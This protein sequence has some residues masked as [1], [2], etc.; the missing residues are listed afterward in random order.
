MTVRGI[1]LI[2]STGSIGTQTLEVVR[3]CPERYRVVA[4]AARSSWELLA[5]QALEHRP[6]LVALSDPTHYAALKEALAGT[7]IRV[8]AGEEAVYEVAAHPEAT[9]VLSSFVG[10]AGMVP[11]LKALEAGKWVALAN[12]EA[13]VVGGELVT[14]AAREAETTLLPVDSEHS[15]IF[16][17]LQGQVRAE[18]I[19]L[20]ASGG[21]FRQLERSALEQVT[22][23]QALKHPTWS[24]G[25]KITIDSSTLMNKGFEV[26]EAHY[27]F[28]M[29][30]SEVDVWVHPQS[31]IHSM[32]EFVDG[33][34]LAQLGPPDMR[35]PIQYALFYPERRGPAW[36][37]LTLEH[38]RQL[39][40]EPPRRDDFPCLDLAF[41]AGR[42]GGTMPAVLNA[43]NEVAVE[44]FLKNEIG[45]LD[46]PR[47]IE[48]AMQAHTRKD[49]PSVSDLLAADAWARTF[50]AGVRA[51]AVNLPR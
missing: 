24:M 22:A 30:L 1:S 4:L 17:C 51:S 48:S 2:G 23:A 12:K 41:E 6:E 13:L 36:S 28:A 5:R 18:R 26:L 44:R 33:S 8:A 43:A 7:G 37:R 45:F 40:F 31:V 32:V 49:G 34:V 50:A 16:Q 11:T 19:I 47:T 27:L 25:A 42:Q 29:S 15:A 20:T 21:P 9:M 46:I 35:T 38:C 3:E 10:M 14:A 39:T